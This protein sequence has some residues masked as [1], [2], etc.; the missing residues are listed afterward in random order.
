[1]NRIDFN[2]HKR[3]SMSRRPTRWARHMIALII[4]AVLVSTSLLNQVEAAAGDLDPA[5]GSGGKVLNNFGAGHYTAYD[6]VVQADSK[7]VVAGGGEGP[8]PPLRPSSTATFTL[9]VRVSAAVSGTTI[10]NRVTVASNFTP[11]PY[12]ANDRAIVY[13]SIP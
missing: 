2:I 3:D 4:L 6:V 7:I 13:T 9:K 12:A 5:F 10:G 8:H 1:M 11:D